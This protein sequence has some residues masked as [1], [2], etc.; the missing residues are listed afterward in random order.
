MT[1]GLTHTEGSILHIASSA[2]TVVAAN[3]VHT[4][5]VCEAERFL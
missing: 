5:S 3:V 1:K 4:V 2:D